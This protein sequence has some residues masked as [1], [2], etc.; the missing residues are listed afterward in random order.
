M[1]AIN[2][3]SN[4]YD[5]SDNIRYVII[6][7]YNTKIFD[8]N[9]LS[10]I[11]DIP[12]I[13]KCDGPD[14]FISKSNSLNIEPITL[15]ESVIKPK[16]KLDNG[17]IISIDQINYY[18]GINLSTKINR[19]NYDSTKVA[20]YSGLKNNI[21]NYM[22]RHSGYYSPIVHDLLLFKAPSLTQSYGNYKF[23]ENLTYF[24]IIKERLVSKVNRQKNI[25]KLKNSPNVK[26]IYP[27]L[28]E[29]GYH[30]TDF[31][32]FKST[33]DYEYHI[34]CVDIPQV[35]QVISNQSLTTPIIDTNSN[36]NLSQL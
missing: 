25:L 1:N 19:V 31:F 6:N 14:E 22:Y 13:L 34:E 29:Y 9:N 10:S 15:P 32:I 2:D 18:S 33:W 7:D 30:P 11:G 3:L 20:N 16:R 8:F 24:G 23:D 21:Y 12:V 28:D 5:F 36:N 35:S 27:M 26:S 17:N 4:K